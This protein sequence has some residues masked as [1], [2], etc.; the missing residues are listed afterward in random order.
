[1]GRLP[2]GKAARAVLA[3][4]SGTGGNSPGRMD[5]APTPYGRSRQND[6]TNDHAGPPRTPAGNSPTESQPQ[7]PPRTRQLRPRITPRDD[8]RQPCWSQAH[9]E[10]AV[11]KLAQPAP[12]REL[13]QLPPQRLQSA[14]HARVQTRQPRRP[15][16]SPPAPRPGKSHPVPGGRRAVAPRSGA[17]AA[18]LRHR[19]APQT[20]GTQAGWWRSGA[21]V[22][23]VAAPAA[24]VERRSAPRRDAHWVPGLV[25][26]V[27]GVHRGVGCAR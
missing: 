3:V 23:S 2:P 15:P 25:G 18:R 14:P 19:Q 12:L 9:D 16:G 13:G 10:A 27:R 8:R 26:R 7:R 4:C 5:T 17:E 6:R 11:G 24:P 1:M 21:R 20:S 22:I